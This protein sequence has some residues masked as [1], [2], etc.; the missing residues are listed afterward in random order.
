MSRS[1]KA[2]GP[3]TRPSRQRHGARKLL[4]LD[5]A[6]SLEAIR[7]R[8]LEH[9]V[10]CRDLGGFFEHVWT[11]HPFATLVTSDAW[12]SRFGRPVTTEISPRHTFIEGKLGRY[13]ALR[14]LAP[15]NF[16]LGQI[17][18]FRQ[19]Y[20]LV[21]AQG[22]SVIRV[23]DPSYPGLL[24]LALSRLC[25]I[26]LVI[27]VGANNRKLRQT[28]GGPMMPR[29]FFSSRIEEAVERF[30]LKRAD[31]VAGINLDNL[32][33]ALAGG[34]RP[35]YSTLFRVGN[36]IDKR[37]LA[38]PSE[39]RGGGRL[40][41]ELG[42]TPNRFILFIG[43]L[44]VEKHPDD[45]VRVLA[46]VRKRQHDLKLVLAGDGKMRAGIAGLAHD[47]GVQDHVVFCGNKDQGWL[48]KV[49]PV[50][51]A[52]LSPITGRA[53][54]EAAFGAAPIVAYDIDWQSELIETGVTG[55]L[56][57]HRSW[58]GMA[59][60]LERFL[61]DPAYARAM[62]ESARERALEMLDPDVLDQHERDQYLALLKRFENKHKRP[63]K[64]ARKIHGAGG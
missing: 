8:G 46:E 47:L 61:R 64:G 54:S 51:A 27:R 10:T 60:A 16:L 4:V 31:L 17:G 7:E 20:R 9:S 34:A 13:G 49:I 55:E 26:P 50:A 21:R 39:R 1:D 45:A 56:V 11:V 48:S 5:T 3:A 37:H 53:L 42:V 14:K 24:G 36:L 2:D 59:N 25:G 15:L 58:I 6:F 33:F 29:L 41:D 63:S 30:V 23:G 57:P 19:L 18:V 43:R 40:C 28:K 32:D 38:A 22:I 35:A 44:L 62:G 12:S 52:V